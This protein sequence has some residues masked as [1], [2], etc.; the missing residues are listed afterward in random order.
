MGQV[1]KIDKLPEEYREQLNA[2]LHD[3]RVNQVTIAPKINAILEADGLPD[4]ISKSGVNR[5]KIKLDRIGKKMRESRVLAD[6]WIDRW[7]AAPQ[8]KVGHLINESLR[9]L[10]L[11]MSIQLHEGEITAQTAPA[12]VKMLKGLALTMQRLEKAASDN[13][14]REKEI[15]KDALEEAARTL[16]SEAKQRGLSDE[17]AE[18]IKAKILGISA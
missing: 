6:M 5:H 12:T 15:R 13:V 7:G 10:A 14:K 11:D 8:G 4:R 17:A 16:D 1:S 2:M 3:P 9:A 18:Q